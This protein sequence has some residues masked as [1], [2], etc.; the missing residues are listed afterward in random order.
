M[1]TRSR[2]TK[3]SVASSASQAPPSRP[4][5][6]PTTNQDKARVRDDF[7]KAYNLAASCAYDIRQVD[8]PK[9]ERIALKTFDASLVR[10]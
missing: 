3:S 2:Q 1:S 10:L 4:L 8:D 5:A 7:A 6:I 9:A